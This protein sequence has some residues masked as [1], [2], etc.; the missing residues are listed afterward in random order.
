MT[1]NDIALLRMAN[2]HL[3]GRKFSN[4][5]AVVESMGAMQA[6]DYDQA[7]WAV[8]SRLPGSTIQ[9]VERAVEEKSI[10]RTWLFR[11]TL[12]LVH[13]K[14]V[15]WM[16]QLVAPGILPKLKTRH[17]ELGLKETQFSTF[18]SILTDALKKGKQLSRTQLSDVFKQKGIDAK[19]PR[20]YHILLKA[21][22]EQVICC[23]LKKDTFRLLEKSKIKMTREESLKEIAGRY[24]FS[25]GPATVDDLSSW[26]GI[27]LTEARKGIEAAGSVLNNFEFADKIY[28]SAAVKS[29]S[30][31]KLPGCMLLAGFDEYYLG[32]KDKSICSDDKYFKN[33]VQKNGIFNPLL[34]INGHVEGVWKRTYEK[35]KIIIEL[36]PF[37]K[38][39]K[40]EKHFI[41]A[42][43]Q[44][45]SIFTCRQLQIKF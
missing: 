27:T 20:L 36:L 7:K 31:Q 25:H 22:L 24:F 9:E 4:V 2:H 10:V 23:G 15:H 3:G 28:W 33:I 42:A 29:K 39:N 30:K 32:Y 17:K 8:G 19:G 34:L 35:E 11:G 12:H 1:K 13:A 26:A 5:P 43:A 45:F 40:T 6:Q 16:L 14:D 18:Y 21:A 38:L 37:R 41:Y 44:K